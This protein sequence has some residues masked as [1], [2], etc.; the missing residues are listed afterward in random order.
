MA[1]DSVNGAIWFDV[2]KEEFGLINPPKRM[3]DVRR[4]FGSEHLVDLNGEAGYLSNMSMEV[5]VL[6][7]KQWVPHC[8]FDVKQFDHSRWIE[9]LGCWNKDGDLLIRNIGGENYKFFVYMQPQRR[10][11]T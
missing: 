6:K 10:R 2:K 7:Q 9:V 1:S 11:F 3:S 8:Q 5:C 4:C